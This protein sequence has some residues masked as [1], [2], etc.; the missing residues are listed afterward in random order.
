MDSAFLTNSLPFLIYISQ[1]SS[2]ILD[3]CIEEVLRNTS[4][5]YKVAKPVM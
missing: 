4:I 5:S 1:E 3:S 2:K